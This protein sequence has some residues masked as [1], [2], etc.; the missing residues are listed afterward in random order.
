[1]KTNT[2]AKWQPFGEQFAYACSVC[3]Y[4]DS[5][6]P[7]CHKCKCEK[8]PGFVFD[9]DKFLKLCKDMNKERYY[10]DGKDCRPIR[11]DVKEL[12]YIKK[13]RDFW[14]RMTDKSLQAI[15]SIAEKMA[16]SHSK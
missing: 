3:F 7:E 15:V 16:E 4:R 5:C 14:K 1:M 6:G 12:D 10:Y 9:P 2:G 8:E 11:F 13:D